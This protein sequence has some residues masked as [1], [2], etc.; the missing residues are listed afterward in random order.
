MPTVIYTTE[1]A[2]PA[3][4]DTVLF[5]FKG[6]QMPTFELKPVAASSDGL[7]SAFR[8]VQGETED[9]FVMRSGRE[10]SLPEKV[11]FDGDRLFVRRVGGKLRAVLLVNGTSVA[12]D[13]RDVVTSDKQLAWIAVSLGEEQ[14]D[15]YTSSGGAN[16]SVPAAGGRKIVIS[17][18]GSDALIGAAKQEEPN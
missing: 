13:G 8:V 9:L 5:P 1:T 11:T 3:A 2:L 12:I 15:V 7:D 6:R 16:V 4:I 17:D 10:A 14:V 18:T